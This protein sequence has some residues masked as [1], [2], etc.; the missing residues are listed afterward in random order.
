MVVELI[1]FLWLLKPLWPEVASEVSKSGLGADFGASGGGER[2]ESKVLVFSS[3]DILLCWGAPSAAVSTGKSGL[4]VEK[5]DDVRV[6][7]FEWR[8]EFS[9]ETMFVGCGL[10]LEDD[11]KALALQLLLIFESVAMVLELF[12]FSA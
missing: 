8:W 2:G 6:E 3:K 9:S 10:P 7:S 4:C 1:K 12:S 5:D 11:N